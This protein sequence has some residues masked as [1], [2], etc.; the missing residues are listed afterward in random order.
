MGRLA[1]FIA[2]LQVSDKMLQLARKVY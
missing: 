2:G 1:D